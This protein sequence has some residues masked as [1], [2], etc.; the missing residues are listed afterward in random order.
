MKDPAWMDG[1]DLDVPEDYFEQ[2]N[3]FDEAEHDEVGCEFCSQER[4]HPED[5]EDDSGD[6]DRM[7][8]DDDN[9]TD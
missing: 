7:W 2:D 5:E 4:C 9:Y 1:N 8:G 3:G 6:P